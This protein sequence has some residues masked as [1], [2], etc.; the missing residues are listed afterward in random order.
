MLIVGSSPS[1]KRSGLVD[2]PML[3]RDLVLFLLI[4]LV[5]SLLQ[6]KLAVPYTLGL[7]V[8]GLILGLFQLTPEAQLPPNLVLFVFL[9]PI[10]FE[11]AWSAKLSLLKENWRVIFFLAGPGL[12][13]SLVI[14]AAILHGVEQL[15]WLTALL[16][17]AILSPTD[18]VPVLGLF[19]HLHVHDRL[20]PIIQA[21]SL[22]TDGGAV[23]P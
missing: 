23:Y 21:E 4:G 1:T 14:I 16:L 17:A 3:I 6:S 13:L 19:R 8:V 9:P 20:S 7:V 18:P 15:D 5:V 22:F 11:G 2:I 12:L 10:L